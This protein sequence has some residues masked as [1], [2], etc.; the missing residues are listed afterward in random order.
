MNEHPKIALVTITYNSSDV[1]DD[2]LT[3]VR[4]QTYKNF[5][6][7]IIDNCSTDNTLEKVTAFQE[8]INMSVITNDHNAGVAAG[9]NQGIKNALEENCEY[10]MLINNDTVFE[11][12]LVEKLINYLLEENISIVA[13][14]MMYHDEPDRIWYGGGKLNRWKG[15]LN[16]HYGFKE[17]DKG[18][19]KTGTVITYAPTCCVLFHYKVF[20]D[21]GLMDEKYF[22]YHDDSDFFYRIL[23]NGSH[24]MKFYNDV[25][26]LHKVG[27]LTK[28]KNGSKENFKFSKFRIEYSTR[29]TI[30]YF[31]KQKKIYTYMYTFLFIVKIYLS[32]IF[33]QKYDSKDVNVKSISNNFIEG[34]KLYLDK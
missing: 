23:I 2:F 7:Y 5:K 31:L 16:E 29:N 33:L 15:Y 30:Y 24:L 22:V 14:K 1:I 19:F 34:C 20:E 10:I 13:P 3:S 9:N 26:F 8:Q 12:K 17:L 4:D 11:E 18:Q 28:S 21:V 25:R 27:S 32:V 6:L